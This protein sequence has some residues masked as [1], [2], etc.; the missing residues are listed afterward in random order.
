MHHQVAKILGS[1]DLS[2]WQ[3]LNSFI[4]KCKIKLENIVFF[5]FM[6]NKDIKDVHN[7]K[8]IFPLQRERFKGKMACSTN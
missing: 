4:F 1:E 6:S 2:L 3:K 8:L 7:Q 5:G